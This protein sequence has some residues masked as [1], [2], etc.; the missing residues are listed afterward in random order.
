MTNRALVL[1]SGEG[2][3][4][5]RAEAESLFL[6]YDE[7]SRFSS[8]APRVLICESESDPRLVG[9][10]IAFAR[11]VGTMVEG[12]AEASALLNGRRIR[13]R[14]FDLRGDDRP[15]DPSD[16]LAGIDASI[17]LKEPEAELTLVRAD[18]DYLAVTHPVDMVQGWSTRRPRRRPFFHPAAIFPKLSRALVNMTRCREGDLFLDPFAGTGS[19]PIEA[20]LVGAKTIA[21]DRSKQMTRGAL[22]NMRHFRQEW[23]GAMRADSVSLPLTAVD[24]VATDIPYG[25]ASSTRGRTSAEVLGGFL[26]ALAEVLRPGR[27]LVLMHQKEVKVDG[28]TDFSLLEEHDLH[29]HKLLTRT[30]SVLRK[31]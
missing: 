11:R 4:I 13:F 29:V 22:A 27:I 5:P 30:I 10:R 25:R 15:P 18:R 23:L 6:A 14:A 9:S 12:R 1:L 3:T 26:P 2:T 24:A 16:Y 17:D 19:L 8:P 21:L 28:A 7:T 31:R 20:A